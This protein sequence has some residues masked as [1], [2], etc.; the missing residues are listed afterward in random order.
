[1]KTSLMGLIRVFLSLQKRLQR[2]ASVSS[3]RRLASWGE[4]FFPVP[5]S[6]GQ[7][8]LPQGS[9]DHEW[10]IPPE[11]ASERVIFYLHGGFTFPLTNPTRFLAGH[12]ALLARMRVLLVDFRLAPEHPFPAALEDCAAAYRWLITEGGFSPENVVL[13]GESA[14]G[15]LALAAMLSLRE[16]GDPLPSKAALISPAVDLA[17]GGGFYTRNDPMADPDFVM[18]QFNAYRGTAD[19]RDPLLSPV[20]ANLGGLPPLQIQVG[21]EEI[22]RGGAEALV[23]R[24]D[25]LGLPVRLEIWP[26]MWHYWH[27][28]LNA[29]PEARQA[30]ASLADFIHGE[31]AE[32]D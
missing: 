11:A 31:P 15:N 29:V 13:V 22:L 30:L 25:D 3:A 5:K 2:Q 4:I 27:I 1:M 6:L 19:P 9:L 32:I 10:L 8:A 20:H 7:F 23:A 18:R 17:G 26:G 14:G 16:A 12:L 28:F 21:S 24:A